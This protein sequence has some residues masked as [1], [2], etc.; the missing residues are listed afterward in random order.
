M[1]FY[2]KSNLFTNSLKGTSL[3]ALVLFISSPMYGQ[4]I[5]ELGFFLVVPLV[6]FNIGT[7]CSS[8]VHFY[9]RGGFGKNI[10]RQKN[11]FFSKYMIF[12]F[13]ILVD[14]SFL[15]FRH[16]IQPATMETLLMEEVIRTLKV[17]VTNNLF[18]KSGMHLNQR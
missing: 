14:P 5:W 17:F 2:N 9:P 6:L 11:S 3:V 18:V 1:T 4:S 13:W 16:S 12:S 10:Q 8:R 15:S 7:D